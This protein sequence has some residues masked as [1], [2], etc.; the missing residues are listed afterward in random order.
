MKIYL[1]S[2]KITI[3]FIFK[4]KSGVIIHFIHI[5]SSEKKFTITA[6][7]FLKLDHDNLHNSRVRY[8][9][10]ASASRSATAIQFY[11]RAWKQSV[12]KGSVL[13][14]FDVNGASFGKDYW[15]LLLTKCN[16]S[17]LEDGNTRIDLGICE[18]L[19]KVSYGNLEFC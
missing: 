15:K 6:S 3:Q 10:T 2:S 1:Q 5:C 8:T 11:D 7:R 13:L 17:I 12:Y 16:N 4:V 18:K 19:A 9:V 14:K